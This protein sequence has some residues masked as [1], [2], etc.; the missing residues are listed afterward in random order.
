MVDHIPVFFAVTIIVLLIIE[1]ALAHFLLLR[2]QKAAQVGART[3][4]TLPPAIAAVPTI[5]EPT[6]PNGGQ[7]IPCFSNVGA[8]NCVTPAGSPWTCTGSACNNLDNLVMDRILF[9]MQ[10]VESRIEREDV[11]LTYTYRRL[12]D[13]NGPF[14]PEVTVQVAQQAYE[15]ALIQLGPSRKDAES[16]PFMVNFIGDTVDHDPTVYAGVVAS[17][18]GEGLNSDPMNPGINP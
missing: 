3:A 15:F 10:R 8:D 4:I 16:H 7:M 11:T 13:A 5:N 12:G 6:T 1:I 14:M 2:S 9:D 18:F 17:A